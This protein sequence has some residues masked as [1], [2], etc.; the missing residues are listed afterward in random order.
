[1]AEQKLIGSKGQK[2]LLVPNLFPHIY[3]SPSS[4]IVHVSSIYINNLK[5]CQYIKTYIFLYF[6]IYFL[7]FF[8]IVLY[9][10]VI[11]LFANI[12]KIKTF[13]YEKYYR[14]E[15]PSFKAI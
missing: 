10:K 13:F 14:W 1:M 5:S 6:F 9:K 15:I 2:D 11:S 7:D 4:F 12:L 8:Y 3:S